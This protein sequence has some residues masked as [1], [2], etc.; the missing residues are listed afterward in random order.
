M[1][2]KGLDIGY[3]GYQG[4][5]QPILPGATGIDLDTPGYDGIKLPF[6]D[7]S[8]DYVYSSHVLEHTPHPIPVLIEWFRV[9][10]TGGYMVIVVPHQYLYEKK[11][12]KPS[13]WNTDH[14]RF[15][16]P[17]NLLMEIDIA[18]EPNTWRLRLLEDGDE[19]FDYSIGP[20]KHSAGQYEITAVVQ[21]IK[22]PAWRLAE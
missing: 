9:L 11:L 12:K 1:N 5:V 14:K 7:E 6:E 15:Y 16:L 10:K 3:K 21:K 17:W 8:H 4:N 22:Q 2:G 20:E 19:G 13:N 18:L